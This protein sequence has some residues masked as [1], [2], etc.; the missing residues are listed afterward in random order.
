AARW[1]LI[2]CRAADARFAAVVRNA[3]KDLRRANHGYVL[4]SRRGV[5]VVVAREW[6][7]GAQAEAAAARR[8]AA[9]VGVLEVIRH[10]EERVHVRVETRNVK[11]PKGI[12]RRAGVGVDGQVG[13]GGHRSSKGAHEIRE[14][15]SGVRRI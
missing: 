14:G 5:V 3:E 2:R 15:M 7:R 13:P 11:K 12:C 9:V 4:L 10:H 8:S 6:S 1:V